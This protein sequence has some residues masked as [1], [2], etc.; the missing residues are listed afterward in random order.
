M[1]HPTTPLL[2][3]LE[4][5]YAHYNRR[6]FVY[7]DPLAPV[8][9]FSDP[10]DQE[11]A[12]LIAASLAFG[13][14][15]IILTSIHRVYEA[16]GHPSELR[17]HSQ[18]RLKRRLSGFRHRYVGEAEMLD[19][20]LGIQAL[21]C[22][23]GSLEAAFCSGLNAGDATVVPAL[24]AFVQRLRTPMRLE[25]NYLISDPARGS[26][27]K[28]LFMYLRWMVRHDAVDPGPWRAISP[29]L[30]VYPMDTHMHQMAR[31]LGLTIRNAADL[32]TALEVTAAFRAIRPDDPVRYDFS[33]TRFGI[34][35]E[36]ALKESLLNS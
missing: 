24:S 10:R 19:L 35:K 4:R 21:L 36:Q 33:L 22:E 3:R 20:L 14:V 13:N 5:I 11:V 15:K 31:T 17:F 23:T 26:A 30:L 32:K 9:E 25:R 2:P 29:A 7:P 1:A 34:R 8:L 18:A 6:A 12:G 16:I 27:C 28:R